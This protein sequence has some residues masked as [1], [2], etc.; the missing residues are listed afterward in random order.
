MAQYPRNQAGLVALATSMV[1]GF[2]EHA[3]IF[4]NANPPALQQAIDEYNNA[5]KAFV[6]AK[7]Q[8]AAAAA[9]K[10]EKF[11]QLQSVIK[12]QIKL[13]EV[14]C[15]DDPCKLVQIGWGPRKNPEGIKPPAPA[16]G[17]KVIAQTDS[18]IFLQW[19][20]GSRNSE[21]FGPVIYYN[22]ERRQATDDG[23]SDWQLA[24]SVANSKVKLTDQPV[25]CKLEYRVMTINRAGEG[26]SND[27]A[28]AIL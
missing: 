4:I 5:D 10:L 8:L 6:E 3:D 2:T 22:I 7:E 14:D 9:D 1:A 23:F 18:T 16:V 19:Q 21:N 11:N 20:K 15:C 13:S 27:T 28:V 26:I 12:G 17:L 24:A 25:G